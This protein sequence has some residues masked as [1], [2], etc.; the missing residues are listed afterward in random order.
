V[1]VILLKIRRKM[2]TVRSA[3]HHWMWETKRHLEQL[4]THRELRGVSNSYE[5]HQ[6]VLPHV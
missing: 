3:P 5:G 1:E 6:T 4:M 2:S